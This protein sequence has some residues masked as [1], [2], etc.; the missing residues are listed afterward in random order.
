MQK[1]ISFSRLI[2]LK[3]IN[4][5]FL[6]NPSVNYFLTKASFRCQFILQIH[7][8]IEANLQI[9]IKCVQFWASFL[10]SRFRDILKCVIT[11]NFSTDVPSSA[12]NFSNLTHFKPKRS[13]LA[14]VRE[15]T[16]HL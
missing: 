15:I 14:E 6:K 12:V 10:K 5:F 4:L 8:F 3:Q 16:L 2:I 13:V 9:N 1:V 7:S 11:V